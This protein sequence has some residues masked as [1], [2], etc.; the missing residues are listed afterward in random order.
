MNRPLDLICVGRAAV[1]LYGEQIGGRLEDMQSF[2]KYLGGSPANTAVGVARLGLQARDADPRRRRAQ[3][4]LS[5][6]KPWPPKAW[7]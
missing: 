5:C 4:P 6:A 3:R 7:T 2:A 1:D